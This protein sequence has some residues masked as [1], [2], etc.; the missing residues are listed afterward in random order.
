M[1]PPA[2][3]T[4]NETPSAIRAITA[5]AA[6]S[7]K[8]S[9]WRVLSK[10]DRS[11]LS[12]SRGLR[13]A[14]GVALPLIIGYA[15]GMPRGGLAVASG[16]LNVSYS[17]S[18]DPYLRRAKR[19]MG[20][21]ILCSL[22][23]FAGAIS[24]P[25][26]I[27]AIL[28]ATLWAFVAGM[29]VVL[30]TSIGDVGVISLVSLLIYA[31][32]PLTPHQAISAGALALGGGFLQ[33]ALSVAL[34]PVQRYEP[35]RRALAN[36]FA[37]LAQ[38]ASSELWS[39]AAPAASAESDAAQAAI[40]G[41]DR[42][43][44]L[45]A[46]RYRSLLNQALRTRLSL[47]ML[48]RLRLRM[49]RENQKQPAVA[50]VDE[51][52]Q[53]AAVALRAI[54]SSLTVNHFSNTRL[55]FAVLRRLAHQLNTQPPQECSTFFVAATKSAAFQIDALAGQLRALMDLSAHSTPAGQEQFEQAEARQPWY[56]QFRGWYATM[57]A[58][59]T[60]ESSGFRHAI[61]LAA[62]AAVGQALSTPLAR[63]FAWRRSYWLPMTIVI[64]LKPEFSSTFSR[65]LLRIGG[66]IVGLLLATALFHFLPITVVS[67]ILLIFAFTFLLRWVGPAN[68]GIFAIAVSALVVLLISITGI[69]PKDVIAQRGL[70]TAVGGA[71]ALLVYWLWPTWERTQLSERVAKMLEAYGE[72]FKKLAEDYLQGGAA[73]EQ[74]TERVRQASRVARSN[75]ESSL[76]RLATEPGTTETQMT[77]LNA[78]LATSHRLV[79]AIMALDAGWMQTVQVP[80]RPPFKAFAT[81]VEKTIAQLILALR[82]AR[83]SASDFPNLREDH[84]HLID[85]GDA[86]IDRYGLVNVEADRITNSLN[87]L[88]EQIL[89]WSAAAHH[90]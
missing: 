71:L 79:H 41:L 82:G 8:Q 2:Y 13:N 38:V 51:A 47:L 53:N 90:K 86:E 50:V 19:M 89:E 72:Y 39:T 29:M 61:R 44:S 42:E 85:F 46:V 83:L 70:N 22:A 88:R 74:A 26:T 56:L 17:D 87:T 21:S 68:Y 34:W 11:K 52:L 4:Q 81:D 57:R 20:S 78:L 84:N 67:Q 5:T 64:V 36:L 76:E 32:Q 58:N 49:V 12:A 48:A 28:V 45:E 24:G 16:A 60:L 54:A 33:T 77:Q 37:E 30:G 6:G 80:A 1:S 59:F 25:H 62:M 10:F 23:I 66:T 40:S 18:S 15:L 55:D 63:E 7:T 31:A 43:E 65:G 73:S 3:P 14:A 9:L 27:V 35:E 69:S 75:L